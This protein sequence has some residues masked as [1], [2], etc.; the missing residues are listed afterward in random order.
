MF[1]AIRE[2]T[3]NFSCYFPLHW[4]MFKFWGEVICVVYNINASYSSYANL[5]YIVKINFIETELKSNE[6]KVD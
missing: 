1:R 5:K 4:P 3:L 6:I 2:F